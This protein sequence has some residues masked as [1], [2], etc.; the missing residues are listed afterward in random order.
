MNIYVEIPARGGSKGVP[1]KALRNLGGKPLIAHTI[2]HALTIRNVNKVCVNTDDME[3]REVSIAHGAEV[4]FLRPQ[5]LAQD[6]SLYEDAHRFALDWYR[7]NEAYVS[8]IAIVMSPTYPF[9]R[10]ELLNEAL[11]IVLG[12]ENIFNVG[13]IAPASVRM[14]N[15]WQASGSTLIRFAF[16]VGK[17]P[18]DITFY[19][20]AFSFNIVC[21]QRTHLPDRRIPFELNEIE[22]IDIDEPADLELARRVMEEGLYPFEPHD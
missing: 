18:V 1:R 15:F 12:D 21:N 2:A 9:R 16:P 22:A 19:Q 13:S 14:D 3:I 20:S 5:E 10:K 8:D 11:E 4:P 6:N 7:D 17:M